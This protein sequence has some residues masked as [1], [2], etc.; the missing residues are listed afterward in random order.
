MST[1]ILAGLS[2]KTIFAALVAITL[3]AV[4]VGASSAS[5]AASVQDPERNVTTPTGWHFWVGQTKAQIDK[6]A[7]DASERVVDVNLDSVVPLRF[8]AVLVRN[9]G[10]YARTGGWS[11]GSE[12][13]VT[14][15]INAEQGRLIDLEPYTAGG[16]RRFAYAWVE[17]TGSAAKGWHWNYD[18]TVKGVT[19]EINKYK[20]RLIDLD[21]Y[22][23]NGKRR[24]SYIGI[25]NQGVDGRAWWWYVNVTP[26]FVQQ[27]AEAN[28]ARLID[29]ERPKAGR[30]S[31]IMVR[32]DEHAYSR[33]V[34][35]Y[36]QTDLLRFLASNGVRITDLERYSKNG[37]T[38]YAASLIDNSSA[39]NR[40]IRSIWRAS[41]MANAPNGTDAWFGIYAK[42]VGGSVDVGLANTRPYQPLS[43]LKLIPHLYVMD[44]LDKDPG[45]DLL[46]KPKGISWRALKGKPDEI[47]CRLQDKGKKTQI[48]SETLRKT[49]TRGL[50]ESLNRAHEALLN[51]Y[52][53]ATIN[54]RVHAMGL[55][56]TNVYPGC[57]QGGGKKDWTYNRSTLSELGELFEHVDNRTFFPNNWSNVMGEFYGLMANWGTTGI[58]NVVVSEAAQ[59][60]KSGIVN[61]FMS[62]VTIDGKGGGTLLPQSDGT[63]N[64]GRGFFGRVQLPFRTGP[65]GQS[66]VIKT[67]VGGYFVDNFKAPCNEDT[68]ANSP[69]QA[70]RD[71]K[72]KQSATYDLLMGEP[73]RL[74]IRRAIATWPRS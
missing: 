46:D 64:G 74:A 50:G 33:H 36:T 72:T 23:V 10:S 31:V 55:T 7:K 32:N 3:L 38:R 71:W 12:A 42:E 30:M 39:E 25:D 52:H 2:R 18:L 8:S 34:Y 44:L 35:D 26:K 59:A 65:R 53:S 51:K 60:G 47:W 29:V 11:Y 24:Y 45:L 14:K 16:K 69:D 67:F 54:T 20:V 70:C 4:T 13:D 49:L 27:H 61:T 22:V 28:S 37:K 21:T 5:P 66:T 48:Y 41:T 9:S 43:V 62:R 40:R 1:T 58:K 6:R 15:K 73:Y 57:K 19:K 63:Y 17:N 56:H 68:A